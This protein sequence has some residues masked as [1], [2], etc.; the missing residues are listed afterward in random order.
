MVMTQL[1]W[2]FGSLK[3]CSP[4]VLQ[5]QCASAYLGAGLAPRLQLPGLEWDPGICVSES[6]QVI[7]RLL[8]WGPR[9]ED[10]SIELAGC[11]VFM[12]SLMGRRENLTWAQQRQLWVDPC[13]PQGRRA[14]SGPQLSFDW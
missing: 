5:L 13:K 1:E 10:H 6:S 8:V 7:L 4:E 14:A 11:L 2:G 3:P 9:L 12:K